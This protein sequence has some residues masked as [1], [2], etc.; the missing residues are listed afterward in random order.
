ML[1]NNSATSQPQSPTDFFLGEREDSSSSNIEIQSVNNRT[2][3]P[4]KTFPVFRDNSKRCPD[5][6]AFKVGLLLN[7]PFSVNRIGLGVLNR[8]TTDCRSLLHIA[9]REGQSSVVRSLL[10]ADEVNVN[11]EDTNGQTPLYIAA[12]K[13]HRKVVELLLNVRGVDV[14]K[15]DACGYAPL[16]IAAREGHSSVVKSLLNAD[17]INVNKEVP[18]RQL[19]SLHIA[20]QKGHWTVVELLMS[21]CGANVDYVSLFEEV[22][23]KSVEAMA[24]TGCLDVLRFCFENGFLQN[25]SSEVCNAA[26]KGGQLD[27]LKF[28]HSRGCAITAECYEIAKA[29]S[30]SHV[31][32]WLIAVGA[33]G[34]PISGRQYLRNTLHILHEFKEHLPAVAFVKLCEQLKEA[35][36]ISK[37]VDADI[38]PSY[39]QYLR[40]TMRILDEFKEHLPS[41]AYV[42]LCEQ[43]KGAYVKICKD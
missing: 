3:S 5:A 26:A 7:N 34:I 38:L 19:T 30:K 25:Y 10:N 21:V 32:E 6:P 15:Y 4:K 27:C 36:V 17:G 14:N 1:N 13:G 33:P 22:N 37:E 11:E 31:M 40:N 39:R 9:A 2:C 12:R 24:S 42:K 23:S 20:A 8:E 43:L 28:V 29:H 18:N 41:V 16:H 35:Y